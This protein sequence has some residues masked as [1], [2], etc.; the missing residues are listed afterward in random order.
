MEPVQGL[1]VVEVDGLDEPVH[2]PAGDEVHAALALHGERLARVGVEFVQ[3]LLGEGL[4]GRA[5][6][7]HVGGGVHQGVEVV[8]GGGGHRVDRDA[9]AVE[10][11]LQP[12]QVLLGSGQ[13]HLVRYGDHG[14]VAQVAVGLQ[15]LHD[16]VEV[17]QR[18]AALGA[19]DVH[20]VQQHPRALHVPQESVAQADALGGALHQAGDVR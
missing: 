3:L 13:V 7:Q 20:H 16:G 9:R 17:L 2:L 8:P 12:R 19:G 4:R 6:R 14:P 10:L 18:V 11:C 5:L 1:L 15:L